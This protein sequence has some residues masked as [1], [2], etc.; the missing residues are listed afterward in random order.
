[1]SI[2]EVKRLIN[3][4][5]HA[6]RTLEKNYYEFHDSL[7][8]GIVNDKPSYRESEVVKELSRLL[9]KPL[10]YEREKLSRIN[11]AQMRIWFMCT[12]CDKLSERSVRDIMTWSFRYKIA[13]PHCKEKSLQISEAKRLAGETEKARQRRMSLQS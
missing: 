5:T 13:C 10:K 1:M 7:V 4:R 8:N 6:K 12:D 2:H 11:K 3:I 9:D